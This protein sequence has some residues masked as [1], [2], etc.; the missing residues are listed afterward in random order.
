MSE[1]RGPKQARL[2]V[3]HPDG[4]DVSGPLLD[5]EPVET[6]IAGT[7]PGCRSDCTCGDSCHW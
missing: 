5:V 3:T 4:P 1:G 2:L 7:T 6:I